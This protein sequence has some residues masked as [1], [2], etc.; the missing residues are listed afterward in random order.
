M[1]QS[2]HVRWCRVSYAQDCQ[3]GGAYEGVT[4]DVSS[5]KLLSAADRTEFGRLP[6]NAGPA[7]AGPADAERSPTR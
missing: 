3:A 4:G 5:E 7:K 6:R 1:E 2:H